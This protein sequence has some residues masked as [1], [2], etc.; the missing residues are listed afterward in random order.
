[1][2]RSTETMLVYYCRGWFRAKKI[3]S[4]TLTEDE[5]RHAYDTR[6][7]YTALVND[8][9]RP[10]CFVECNKDYV[11]VEFLDDNLRE[12]IAYQFQERK[13]G[14]LFLSMAM[15]R[16]YVGD[17]DKV[18]RGASFIF[19]EDGSTIIYREDF[20]AGVLER[21]DVRIDVS[22][23]WEAYPDFGDYSALVQRQRE[24]AWGELWQ[25]CL[26]SWCGSPTTLYC[27]HDG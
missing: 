11:G 13:P 15:R 6:T 16:N 17:S 27:K 24:K 3:A 22:H 1:M 25:S 23:N 26:V 20:I 19:K 10:S 8:K 5:A 4:E 7:L 18:S 12:H 21:A 14:R 9:E 2:E